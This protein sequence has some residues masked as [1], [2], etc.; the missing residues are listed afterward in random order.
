M[1]ELTSRVA[2]MSQSIHSASLP[3]PAPVESATPSPITPGLVSPG[4]SGSSTPPSTTVPSVRSPASPATPA[5][6]AP[7]PVRT[8]RR[9]PRRLTDRPA[10]PHV[11]GQWGVYCWTDA[12]R[13]G[14]G[15]VPGTEG[16]NRWL[17]A[18]AVLRLREEMCGAEAYVRTD[19]RI[20]EL[21]REAAAARPVL[22]FL[23]P[24]PGEMEAE[25]ERFNAERR[26]LAA[27]PDPVLWDPRNNIPGYHAEDSSFW[28]GGT[29]YALGDPFE[30]EEWSGF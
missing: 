17:S 15:L 1:V 14:E 16:H 22:G 2:T 21:Q 18:C 6:S 23:A 25:E 20:A 29:G 13:R 10:V 7:G 12:G 19:R 4:A 30:L 24:A 26:A 5:A 11:R 9:H 27:D 3:V 28:S 8:A